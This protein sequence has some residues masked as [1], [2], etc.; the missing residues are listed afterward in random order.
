MED[1]AWLLAVAARELT[2]FAAA[3]LLIGGL[4]DLAMDVVWLARGCWR[5][6]FVFTR[7]QRAT[8]ET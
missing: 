3:G 8:L 7:H 2:L 5:R 6:L 4:D 1:A